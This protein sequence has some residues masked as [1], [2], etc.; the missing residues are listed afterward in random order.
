MMEN[1]TLQQIETV[2]NMILKN[3]KPSYQTTNKKEVRVRCPYCGDSKT[4][5][6]HAH[7]YIQMLPPFKFYCQRC[8]TA[9]ALNNQSLRDLGLFNNDL[10]VSIID[11]NKNIKANKGT[12][13]LTFKKS[14]PLL[15]KV[16]SPFSIN[17]VNYTSNRFNIPFTNEYL[18]DRFKAIT[19][20]IQFFNDNKIPI[21]VDQ[22]RR[23]MYDFANSIG[24]MSSDGSH[25][26]FRDI[27]GMQPKRYFNLSISQ[28]ENTLASKIYN[29]KRGIDIMS[30]EINL[31]MTE[32]IFDIIGVYEHFYKDKIEDASNYIFSA[33]AGKGYNAV[34]SHYMRMGFLN[35][36]ITIYSDADVGAGF[37]KNLKNSSVYLKNTPITIY[38]NSKDKDF[39]IPKEQIA[40]K[41][42]IV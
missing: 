33:A 18:V 42:V 34:I 23:P 36:N 9:G 1:N 20:S 31:V 40:L 16:E 11:A 32:G 38:Y 21:P 2:R 5:K 19:N 35:L 3:K 41:K 30:D 25:V 22:Y 37:F 26:I 27:T 8:N 29:I 17:A 14:S 24:F 15:N 28:N 10:S 6:N 13:K 12:E 7:M 39:G 4:D